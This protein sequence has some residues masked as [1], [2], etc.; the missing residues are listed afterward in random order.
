MM[1]YKLVYARNTPSMYEERTAER[2]AAVA[3]DVSSYL[4]VRPYVARVGKNP[5]PQERRPVIQCLR[6]SACC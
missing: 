4:L 5:P 2:T 6:V 1:A 3:G